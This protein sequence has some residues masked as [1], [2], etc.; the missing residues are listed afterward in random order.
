MVCLEDIN[1]DVGTAR[2]WG[3]AGDQS[4]GARGYATRAGSRILTLAFGELGLR[5]VHTWVVEGNPSIRGVERLNFRFI[6]RQRQCHSIDGHLYDRLW[7]DLLASEH[8]E[9]D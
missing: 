4:F 7:F 9:I 2:F 8:R 5:A 3:V 1:R 6:G